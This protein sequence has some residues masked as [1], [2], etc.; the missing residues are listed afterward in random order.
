MN[1]QTNITTRNKESMLENSHWHY[2]N[3]A[4]N[5]P[6]IHALIFASQ[7]VGIFMTYIQFS[8]LASVHQFRLSQ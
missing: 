7:Y 6:L 2:P 4:S 3:R 8:C 1:F 5:V